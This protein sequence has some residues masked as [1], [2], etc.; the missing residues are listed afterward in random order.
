MKKLVR[1]FILIMVLLVAGFNAM[2]AFAQSNSGNNPTITAEVDRYHVSTDETVMLTI[3]VDVKGSS[4]SKP[5]L[6][7]LEGFT[8][9]RSSSGAQIKVV[10][11][12]MSIQ[13]TYQ[14]NLRPTQTGDLVIEPVTVNVNGITFSTDPIRI[15][16]TQ[17]S[18]NIQQVPNPSLPVMPSLPSF[19][20]SPFFD[21]GIFEPGTTI[22]PSE[23]PTELAGQDFFIEAEV[24]K[25]SPFMGEQVIYT[26]RFYN[27][28]RLY[29]DPQ[30]QPP[31]F[32]GFWHENQP[33][34][35]NYSLQQTG[36]TY[37]VTELQTV[38]FPTVVGEINIEPAEITI[39]GGFF[40]NGQ[41]L[42]TQPTTLDVQILPQNAPPSFQ[43]A[44]GQFDIQ[45]GVDT[46]QT[47]INEPVTLNL[48]INGQ[49][50][51]NNL[52]DPVWNEG[53]EWRA[54]DSQASNSTQFEGGKLAGSRTYE[55]IL[56]PTQ[57][58]TLII[59]AVEFSYFDP[60]TSSYK[61]IS[62]QPF[63]VV[64]ESSGTGS[65]TASPEV[66][67]GSDALR[68][69]SPNSSIRPNKPAPPNWI[70]GSTLLTKRPEY[71]LLWTLPLFLLMGQFGWQQYLKR[72]Q[73]N[74][75]QRRRNEAAKKA[76]RAIRA[77]HK[78]PAEVYD[79]AV[80][81]LV[82]FISEKLTRP[83]SGLTQ[84]ELDGLLRSEGVAEDLIERVQNCITLSEFGRFAPSGENSSPK[85][86]LRRTEKL[87][88]ELDKAL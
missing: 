3:T 86:L 46:N 66:N 25:L 75:S 49:G 71:W 48:T 42:R 11:G 15:T 72:W 39:S 87:I 26:L 56:V 57:A 58:G 83:I 63:E 70:Q 8:I 54:F 73:I 62:T 20:S 22:E 36:R 47:V 34:E 38:L 88:M 23:T 74:P 55:R 9:I 84:D 51:I 85:E 27:A 43:G 4:P 16:V 18:G 29:D 6:P 31:S 5:Q 45:A 10:N 79:A 24:D 61:T 35:A 44:V 13:E 37:N 2:P 40:S 50:N 81:I 59:P 77:A 17:G 32:T 65:T 80:Q 68:N 78:R 30:Y 53:P 52:A 19:P 1:S 82:T 76:R 64:V 33:D 12:A 41:I 69:E 14:Y 28:V 21:S 7:L 60:E 67:S